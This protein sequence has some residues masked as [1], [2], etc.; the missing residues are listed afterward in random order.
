MEKS[1]SYVGP[2]CFTVA[3]MVVMLLFTGH[4]QII[5]AQ[6][7]RCN[8]VEVSWCLQ[9]IVANMRPSRNCCQRL[10]GQENC[11]CR[12]THDPTFGGYLRLPGARRVANEFTV[13]RET[14]VE[15]VRRRETGVEVRN[16]GVEEW[17]ST[18]EKETVTVVGDGG[19]RGNEDGEGGRFSSMCYSEKMIGVNSGSMETVGVTCV[20]C[21]CDQL[22]GCTVV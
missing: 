4:L 8:A 7:T 15:V 19:C 3:V 22:G 11:L 16:R 2:R 14:W 12:E 17:S 5:E 1:P 18:G 6:Q 9:A 13:E 10:K 20:C 21:D